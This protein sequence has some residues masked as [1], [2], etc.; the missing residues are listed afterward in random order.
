MIGLCL[1]CGLGL[2]LIYYVKYLYSYWERLGLPAL[3]AHIPFGCL[4]PMLRQKM[5]M[6]ELIRDVHLQSNAP[7]LG[8]Y[9]FCRPT[10]LIRDPALVKRVLISDFDHFYDR[11]FHF[12]EVNDP[13]GAHLFAMQG[14]LWKDTRNLLSPTFTSGKLKNMLPPI[15][16]KSELLKR[17]LNKWTE[18]ENQVQLKSV[19]IQLN[20]SI[21][22]SVFFGFELNAFEEPDHQFIKMGDMHFDPNTIRNNVVNIGFFLCPALL[23]WSKLPSVSPTVSKYVLNLVKSVM[24]AREAD[25]SLVRKDFIQTVMELMKDSADD[26]D[27]VKFTVEKCAAQSFLMYI[28]GYE[29]SAATASFCMW[30]L[31]NNPLWLQRART[32][33]D[34]LMK[35]CG[36]KIQYEDV[37]ELKVVNMCIKEAMRKYPSAPML[38]RECTKEYT[39]PDS[40]GQVIPKGTPI[41]ISSFGLHMDP[42]NFPDPERFNPSRFEAD[43]AADDLP[44]YPVRKKSF[45]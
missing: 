30:E 32:E 23:K 25:P 1:M 40:N 13:I 21:I 11:G 39:I 45:P 36:G 44:F 38:N 10:L 6:G 29:T 14:K 20:L 34:A 2:V 33:V 19:L 26:D 5:S 7:Y 42:E 22:A 8:V 37:N 3:K 12:D 24:E 15:V 35:K 17:H 16:A 43:N 41:L 31:C 27:A 28:A 4:G 9:L 18:T